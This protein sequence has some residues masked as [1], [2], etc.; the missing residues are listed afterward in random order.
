MSSVQASY[1]EGSSVKINCTAS[2]IPDPDVRWMR[3]GTETRSGKKTASLTFSR[4]NRTDD[5]LYACRANNSAGNDEN[6]VALVVHCKEIYFPNYHTLTWKPDLHERCFSVMIIPV[7]NFR[8]FPVANGLAIS[9][10]SWKKR[11]ILEEYPS[12]RTFLT[13]NFRSIWFSSRNFRNFRIKCSLFE[14]QQFPVFVNAYFPRK[15]SN[16]LTPL[17]NF[18]IFG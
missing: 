4:I 15:L 10:I 7:L 11:Q 9:S 16:H 8:K 1:N 2:G 6:H 17:R 13:G 14:I 5:G 12:C 18:G 3:N